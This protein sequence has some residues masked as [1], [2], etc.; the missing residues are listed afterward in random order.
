MILAECVLGCKKINGGNV[1]AKNR[2]R[3]Y[4]ANVVLIHHNDPDL[5]YII[6]F[7]PK[8]HY[9]EGYNATTGIAIMNVALV[10][11]FKEQG[12]DIFP[13]QTGRDF[14]YITDSRMHPVGRV[15]YSMGITDGTISDSTLSFFR[16]AKRERMA[17]STFSPFM[18]L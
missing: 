16:S 14:P 15:A 5:E 12:I 17:S 3:T 13:A 1:I 9:I 18:G 8:T 11:M 10:K 7:D 2:D 4:D 6:I